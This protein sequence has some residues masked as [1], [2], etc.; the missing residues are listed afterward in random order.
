MS[1]AAWLAAFV[2]A[3]VR[4]PRERGALS[5][6]GGVAVAAAASSTL[7]TL[8]FQKIESDIV[9]C[10]QRP[11]QYA[12]TC[13]GAICTQKKLIRARFWP[14]HTGGWMS[15]GPRLRTGAKQPPNAQALHVHV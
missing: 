11:P 6:E 3:E 12:C 4:G 5:I 1:L 8:A 7:S 14:P 13:T 2:G 9:A 15:N 10:G